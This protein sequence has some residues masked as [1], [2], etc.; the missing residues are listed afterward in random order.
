VIYRR[1]TSADAEGIARVHCESWHTTYPGL[2]DAHLIAEFANC[3]RRLPGW[4]RTLEE[5]ASIVWVALVD[6]RVVGFA[7]GG[8]ARTQEEGCDGQLLG[9]YLLQSAQRAGIGSALASSVFDD[10]LDSGYRAVRVELFKG[11]QPA[12]DFYKRLGA[13]FAREA[14]FEMMGASFIEE[15]YVWLDL[16]AAAK[17]AFASNVDSFAA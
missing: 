7:A 1:A 9:I 17:A 10:L 5:G 4:V 11:N 16:R 6:E 15:I 2:I 3:E 8:S 14:P 13:R 12:A